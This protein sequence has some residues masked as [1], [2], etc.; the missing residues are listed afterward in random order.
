MVVSHPGRRL[1]ALLVAAL[2][3]PAVAQDAATPERVVEGVG[4]WEVRCERADPTSTSSILACEMLQAT[5][6]QGQAQPI[7][8]IAIGRPTADADLTAVIQLPLGLWL[9]AGATLDL[10]DA[11][12]TYPITILRCLPNGCLGELPL[13][14]DMRTALSDESLTGSALQFEMQVGTP[15]RV[16]VVHQGFSAALTALEGRLAVQ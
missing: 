15:A 2:P 16:P 11:G 3:I 4:A 14:D 5:T 13:T 12:G 9:P 1:L 7:S 10:G 8:Q 6:M